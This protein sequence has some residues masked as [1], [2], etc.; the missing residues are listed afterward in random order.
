MQE[1][2]SNITV[3]KIENLKMFTLKEKAALIYHPVFRD[4]LSIFALDCLIG[5]TKPSAHQWNALKYLEKDAERREQNKL[6]GLRRRRI[7][8]K[9]EIAEEKDD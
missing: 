3:L 5:L 2:A 4:L 6:D 1:V 8:H 9:I 7:A